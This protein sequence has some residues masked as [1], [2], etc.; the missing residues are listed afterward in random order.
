[1][2]GS[3]YENLRVLLESSFHALLQ[4]FRGNL[5]LGAMILVS[6]SLGLLICE[7]LGLLS[8]QAISVSANL[9]GLGVGGGIEQ[10]EQ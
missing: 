4:A 7:D 3:D 9:L 2:R 10:P 5:C 8:V 1:M 6:R